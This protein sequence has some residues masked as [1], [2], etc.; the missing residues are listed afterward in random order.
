MLNASGDKAIGFRIWHAFSH[1]LKL[2]IF[3]KAADLGTYF[4]TDAAAFRDNG[5][6]RKRFI[7]APNVYRQDTY[8]L[9]ESKVTDN[10][11][12]LGDLAGFLPSALGKN[13]SVVTFVQD[14]GYMTQRL[15][16]TSGSF[17]GT[18]VVKLFIYARLYFVSNQ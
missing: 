4:C 17:D 16:Q 10:G 7:S 18:S 14:L 6:F 15:T 1:F 12:E 13:K 8:L 11:L 5:S 3:E 2:L 9:V